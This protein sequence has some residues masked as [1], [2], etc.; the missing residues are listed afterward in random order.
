MIR[1]TRVQ[2]LAVL[3]AAPCAGWIT[4]RDRPIQLAAGRGGDNDFAGPE[5]ERGAGR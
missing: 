2:M 4:G 3:A 5:A 1:N